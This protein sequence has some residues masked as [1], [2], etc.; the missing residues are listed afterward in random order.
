MQIE[1]LGHWKWK[2]NILL[3]LPNSGRFPRSNMKYLH[4]DQGYFLVAY[5]WENRVL[6]V[7]TDFL[8][9]KVVHAV[10]L[11]TPDGGISDQKKPISK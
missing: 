9:L 2:Q 11:W 4:Q 8:T 5:W 10:R 6:E 3:C 7:L 1:D